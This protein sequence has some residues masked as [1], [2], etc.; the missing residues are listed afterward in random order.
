LFALRR[1]KAE[2]ADDSNYIHSLSYNELDSE[3]FKNIS[4]A[5][6]QRLQNLVLA[7]ERV[8]DH[9][10]VTQRDMQRVLT[11]EQ[12]AEYEKSFDVELSHIEADYKDTMPGVLYDYAELV[13]LGDK[14]TRT[15]NLHRRAVKRDAYGQTAG[16]RYHIKAERCYEKAVML[17]CN[18]LESDARRNPLYDL[19]LAAE[20]QLW[21]DRDVDTRDG[22]QPYISAEG[23]PRL[24]GRKSKHSQDSQRPV[25]GQRLRKHWRQ[26]FAL[27]DAALDLIYPRKGDG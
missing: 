26:R 19:A 27:V 25:V 23:V 21:L 18:V 17:L 12:Y 24:R 14:Y 10:A 22:Y 13:K 8:A 4:P 7:L 11:A 6:T 5:D 2:G 15:A 3:L 20:V 9:R 16:Q 1:I